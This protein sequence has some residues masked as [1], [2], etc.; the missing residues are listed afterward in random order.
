MQFVHEK[1]LQYLRISVALYSLMLHAMSFAYKF[2][3]AFPYSPLSRREYYTHKSYANEECTPKEID[4]QQIKLSIVE[5]LIGNSEYKIGWNF[6]TEQEIPAYLRP[7]VGGEV[8]VMRCLPPGKWVFV[9]KGN[10]TGI[11]GNIVEAVISGFS[12]IE[13]QFGKI[14]AEFISS[15]NIYWKPMVGD[16]IFPVEKHI[17]RKIAISPRVEIPFQDLFISSDLNQYSYEISKQGED[18]LK[19]KFSQFKKLNGRI[20]IESFILTSGNREQLRIES[21]IRAQSVSKYLANLYN[22]ESN[23]IVTI[24]YGNDWLQSG[25]QPIK[26]WPNNNITSGIIIR[27]LPA[28]F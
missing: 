20:L 28:N 14:P 4:P 13:T 7:T 15:G 8:Q 22:I 23:Q 1:K 10:V 11:N 6:Y 24:G 17:N 16:T 26:G 3:E 21:L 5:K 2:P 19:E 18:I 12:D 9:G 25:L 27:M